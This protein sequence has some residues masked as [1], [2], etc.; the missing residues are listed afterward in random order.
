M[1]RKRSATESIDPLVSSAAH[2]SLRITTAGLTPRSRTNPHLLLRPPGRRP[3]RTTRRRRVDLVGL[4]EQGGKI[5]DRP[6]IGVD[7]AALALHSGLLDLQVDEGLRVNRELAGKAVALG[8]PSF[9]VR[10]AELGDRR[11]A[12]GEG[13][14]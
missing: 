6:E 10:G 4:A 11:R 8:L 12:Q 14:N 2:S 7:G 5:S 9:V 1:R 13:P 3:R